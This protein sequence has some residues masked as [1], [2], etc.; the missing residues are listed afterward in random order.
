MH[1]GGFMGRNIIL[2]FDGTNNE[3]AATNTNVVK[4]YAMLDRGIPD[5]FSYYQPGIGTIPPPGLLDKVTK[6]L[7]TRVDLAFAILLDDHVA[8]GYRFLMRYYRADDRIFI[9]GFSRGAYTARVLAGMLH[10]MGLLT[11]G[12]EELIPFAWDMY[13]R[14]SDDHVEEGFRNTFS[15]I[16][17]IHF[18]GVWDTVSSVGYA[19]RPK[20]FP[21]TRN[22][23]S[24]KTFRHAVALDERRRQ[25]VQNL[26]TD[27]PPPEQN[28]RE[29]WFAGVHSDVGG[30]Y[31]EQEAGLSKIALQW[32]VSEAK[33]SGLKV[34]AAMESAVLPNQDTREY[35]APNC[36][37]VQHESLKGWWWIVEFLP[38]PRRDPSVG[39]RTR[40]MIHRGKPRFVADGASLH[41]SIFDRKAKVTSYD[42]KNIPSTYTTV[43]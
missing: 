15:R 31:V 42:P 35:V 20:F 38:L 7:I 12:N 26:W 13:R 1:E 19:T 3:Y 25:F 21:F 30:G 18:L 28:V 11:A 23:P 37:A 36:A 9:F 41:A 39:Y 34:N 40:W 27:K 22:N 32:M 5:Q 17:S 6:W 8:A 4:L 14:H 29:V 24:V 2:C 16:V 10:K 33:V 43:N